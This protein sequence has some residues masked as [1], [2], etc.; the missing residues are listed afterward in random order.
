MNLLYF[1]PDEIWSPS[2]MELESDTEDS[3]VD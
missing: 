1:D 2:I 3:K